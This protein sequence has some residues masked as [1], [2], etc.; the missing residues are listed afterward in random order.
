[1]P[2]GG[3][4]PLASSD[5]SITGALSCAVVGAQYTSLV[6]ESAT[7][8]LSPPLANAFAAVAALTAVDEVVSSTTNASTTCTSPPRSC[9]SADA[10]SSSSTKGAVRKGTGAARRP[11]R[12]VA[13]GAGLAAD[14]GAC[15]AGF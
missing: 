5:G 14:E 13:G 7:P 6:R 12:D 1:M 2:G 3:S 9:G 15:D 4:P 11:Q 10:L 8:A